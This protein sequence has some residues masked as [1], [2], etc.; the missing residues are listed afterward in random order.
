M[1]LCVQDGRIKVGDRVLAVADEPVAGLS[2]DKV[3]EHK[4]GE[5]PPPHTP[6]SDWFNDLWVLSLTQVSSLILKHRVTV[7]LSISRQ[8]NL[9]PT[10]LHSLH[11]PPPP[12]FPYTSPPPS[13]EPPPISSSPSPTSSSCHPAGR[14]DVSEALSCPVVGGRECMI[15]ICKGNVGLGLSIVGGCDT[16]LV[17]AASVLFHMSGWSQSAQK[18]HVTFFTTRSRALFYIVVLFYSSTRGR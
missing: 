6:R 2:A 14:S 11:I 7:E 5:P 10:A 17:R 13:T 8:E 3:R 1:W 12:P 9:L 15:E 16:L 18:S 4:R